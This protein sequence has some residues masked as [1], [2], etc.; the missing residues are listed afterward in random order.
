MDFL[1]FPGHIRLEWLGALDLVF[2]MP[3]MCLLQTAV[4]I[5]SV[6]ATTVALCLIES[7]LYKTVRSLRS[8]A[9]ISFPSSFSSFLVFVFYFLRL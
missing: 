2:L 7:S 1:Q 3:G 6:L 8:L 5:R 9:L 4:G